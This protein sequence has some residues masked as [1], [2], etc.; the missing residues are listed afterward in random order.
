MPPS[1]PPFCRSELMDVLQVRSKQLPLSHCLYTLSPSTMKGDTIGD[2]PPTKA[3]S[4]TIQA[5]FRF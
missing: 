1:F 3:T 5:T 2:Y 4:Y